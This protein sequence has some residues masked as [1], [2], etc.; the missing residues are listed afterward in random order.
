MDINQHGSSRG[1][2]TCTQLRGVIHDWSLAANR[3]QTIHCIYFYS[4]RA[5]DRVGH[6]LLLVKLGN[7]SIEEIIIKW[8]EAYLT[9]ISVYGVKGISAR[10]IHVSLKCLRAS[11][12]VQVFSS[13]VF[14][15]LLMFYLRISSYL[16]MT[17]NI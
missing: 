5:F 10:H 3:C 11:V 15:T 13:C 4:S 14:M 9:K 6:N 7:I 17:S 12:W 1:R 16:R 8:I 2:S